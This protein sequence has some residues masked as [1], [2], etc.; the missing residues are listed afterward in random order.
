MKKD[1]LMPSLLCNLLKI[2]YPLFQAGMVWVSGHKLAIACAKEGM[3]GLLGA[4]SMSLEILREHLEHCRSYLLENRSDSGNI[5]INIPLLY[6][7][8]K[9]QID[10]ALE[11]GLSIFITSAGN[12]KKYTAFIKEKNPKAI[13]GHVISSPIQAQ[14]AKEAGVDFVIAEGMEAGGHNALNGLTSLVLLQHLLALN[15]SLPVVAAGGFFHGASLKAAFSLKASG[16]QLGTLFV[17]SKESSA[18]E[19]Y[20]HLLLK[21]STPES[22]FLGLQQ[23]APVR[24]FKNEFS[25]SLLKKE[26]LGETKEELLAFLGK[27]RAK[28]GMFEG[29]INQG[30]LE[31]GQ[32]C[33]L[34]PLKFSQ[35][36]QHDIQNNS[37]PTVKEILDRLLEE[38]YFVAGQRDLNF[39]L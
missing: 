18:H 24:L 23:I 30:E 4:G 1:I 20:K 39:F 22:T 34:F 8:N 9:E 16:V 31:I 37:F 13:V 11:Y 5:G 6:E 26:Q 2:R 19:N 35:D 27:G 28:Q 15:F 3:L 32:S 14:K 29:D 7:K 10:L 33:S 17:P 38:Y 25:N 36:I 12:P 21:N